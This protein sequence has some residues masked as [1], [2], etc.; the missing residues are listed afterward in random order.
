MKSEEDLLKKLISKMVEKYG[1]DF[2]YI[3]EHQIMG[4]KFWYQYYTTTEKEW[5]A[6]KLWAV[7]EI[8]KH[9]R[10]SKKFAEK[11]FLWFDLM[12]G[13]KIEG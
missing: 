7:N 11:K 5:E 2:D 10:T 3:M 1:I 8:K 9:Y 13:L 12:W 4:N 6:F